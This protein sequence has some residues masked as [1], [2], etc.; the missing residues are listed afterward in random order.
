MLFE[1]AALDVSIQSTGAPIRDDKIGV[2][3]VIDI[4]CTGALRPSDSLQTD[5]GSHFIKLQ[6]ASVAIET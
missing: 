5:L 3:I 2:A 1:P 6:L 4:G